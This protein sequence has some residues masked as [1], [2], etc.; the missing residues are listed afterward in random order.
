M[1]RS[2]EGLRPGAGA[3]RC[4]RSVCARSHLLREEDADAADEARIVLRQAA[5]ARL[6]HRPGALRRSGLRRAPIRRAERP[7]L[8]RLANLRGARA[9]DE[10]REPSVPTPIGLIRGVCDN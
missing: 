3:V 5:A 6:L 10:V 7:S 4:G 2:Q 9:A 1:L 8:P